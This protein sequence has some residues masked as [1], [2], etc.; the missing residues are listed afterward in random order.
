MYT[1]HKSQNGFNITFVLEK[2]NNRSEYM[3]RQIRSQKKKRKEKI[4]KKRK[5]EENTL[6]KGG[7]M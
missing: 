3:E 6:W 2:K 7:K 1:D 5:K 4:M